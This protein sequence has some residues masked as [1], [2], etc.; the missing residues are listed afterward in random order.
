MVCSIC[1]GVGHNRRTCQAN[2]Q[3]GQP[4]NENIPQPHPPADDPPPRF[5]VQ[6]DDYFNN[7][8][9]YLEKQAREFMINGN[10]NGLNDDSIL[11]FKGSIGLVKK[12]IKLINISRNSLC[13]YMVPQNFGVEHDLIRNNPIFLKYIEPRSV[14]VLDVFSGY[15]LF[16][17]IEGQELPSIY[18]VLSSKK[19]RREEWANEYRKDINSPYQ[20]LLTVV[21]DPSF[22]K[23]RTLESIMIFYTNNIQ[24]DILID[25]SKQDPL[26]QYY[27]TT[28][29]KENQALFSSLKMN[30]LIQQMIRLGGLEHETLGSIL[31]LHQDIQIPPHDD[32]DLEASGVPNKLF[33][34]VT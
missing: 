15:I 30:Y 18:S 26:D 17:I 16:L 33:T 32:L 11:F 29:N 1:G 27:P 8:I 19:P 7:T 5:I 9:L 12:Q 34:N 21:L 24:E 28:P 3:P 25:S 4:N 13:L 31:D 23:P 14:N 2:V 20:Q 22:K 6:E 10:I